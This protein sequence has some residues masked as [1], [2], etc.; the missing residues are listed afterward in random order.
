MCIMVY[1]KSCNLN[2][3]D[4]RTQSGIIESNYILET[5]VDCGIETETQIIM[6]I[7]IKNMH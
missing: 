6:V 4:N 5:C 2:D 1:C 3:S 7:V